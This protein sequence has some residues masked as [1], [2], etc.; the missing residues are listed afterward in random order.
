MARSD[1]TRVSGTERSR[2][3]VPVTVAGPSVRRPVAR[4]GRSRRR[5]R[6]VEFNP[7]S[8]DFFDDP[9]ETY[10][11][12]RD[13]APVYH[14]DQ[15][16]FWALSRYDDVVA[17]HRDWKVFSSTPRGDHRSTH[18]PSA[19]HGQRQHHLP[20]SARARAASSAGEPGLHPEGRR[21]P[22]TA[23]SRHR[24]RLPR[25]DRRRRRVRRRGRPRRAVPG[26]GDLRDPRRSRR[27]TGSRSGT[28][29]TTCSTAS[30]TTRSRRR[31]GWRRASTARCTSSSSCRRSAAVPPT[32]CS[33][34]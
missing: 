8:A 1:R 10:G 34:R 23:D 26:R 28:G 12:L 13:H 32:T 31:P 21:R 16:G 17:A 18:R 4:R 24:R 2:R 14:N 19:R 25:R 9:Y 11:W 33:P 30:P 6:S 15:Y 27:A 7:F 20:R 3:W 22:R 5:L 29:S